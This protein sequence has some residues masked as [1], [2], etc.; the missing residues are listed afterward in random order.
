MYSRTLNNG[1]SIPCLGFGTWHIRDEATSVKAALT[2]GYRHIDTAQIYGNEQF[3]GQAITESGIDR[4]DI[5][6]TTKIWN[7]NYWWD[8]LIPSYE[9]SLQKLGTDYADL[10]LLHFPVTETRGPA[11]RRMEYLYVQEKVRAIGV[12]NY[13][14]KHL[15]ELLASCTVRPAVNQVEM[16]VYLQQPEL[17]AFCK[18]NDILVEAY[19]PLAH[20]EGLDNPVLKRIAKKH[21]V[22]VAQIMIAWCLSEGT[23]PLPKATKSTHIADNLAVFDLNLDT[24]DISAIKKLH[25][26]LRT[27][28]D[29][30]NIP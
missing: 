23:V 1:V 27:S 13:T 21:N 22:S 6:V 9:E 28:W 14:V 29:P 20:G 4:K 11:W 10:V 30:T 12:S 8:D 17:L 2:A 7:D 5:F 25:Q 24:E 3:V 16:H 26:N 15:K 19:S 18:E